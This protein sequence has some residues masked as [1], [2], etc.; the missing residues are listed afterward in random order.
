[1]KKTLITLII[2]STFTATTAFAAADAGSWYA[3]SKFGWSHYGDT[4]SQH[5][6][7]FDRD[8]VGGGIFTGYQINPWLAVEGGY[9][10][11]GNMGANGNHGAS[12]SQ[13]KSQ[14]L[15]VSL[16][17][18]Y[19]LSSDWDLYGRAGVMGYRAESDIKGHNDFDTGIRPVLAVG[20]EYAF[21]ENWAG[22]LEYQW[23]SNVGNE[24]QI[25]VSSDISSVMAGISY[26]F[27]Q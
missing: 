9:D 4:N 25:G 8:N 16:K 15:Q 21:N 10:Y 20:T 7:D 12:G 24:N 3:G 18:S 27:G 22:R 2:A 17:A 14:G 1:M 6:A 5:D 13:M 23:V 19:G 11:L 26:R